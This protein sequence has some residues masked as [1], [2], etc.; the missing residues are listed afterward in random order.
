MSADERD[1]VERLKDFGGPDVGKNSIEAAAEITR[2]RAELSDALTA[3]N[4]AQANLFLLRRRVL[5]ATELPPE[6]KPLDELE[7]IASNR[8][9]NEGARLTL[10]QQAPIMLRL[11]QDQRA[12]NNACKEGEG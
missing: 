10:A 1:I 12:L 3:A 4:T 11:L 5:E 8:L 9:F 6:L 2:L 7:S